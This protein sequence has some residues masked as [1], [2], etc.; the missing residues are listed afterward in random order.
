[1]PHSRSRQRVFWAIQRLSRK[2]CANR[3]QRSGGT[4]IVAS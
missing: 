2:S 3:H 4:G 1:M